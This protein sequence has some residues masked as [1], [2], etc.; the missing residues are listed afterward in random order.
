MLFKRRRWSRINKGE[1]KYKMSRQ[2]YSIIRKC[3]EF[4][5]NENV[6]SF[7]KIRELY[8]RNWLWNNKW[9]RERNNKSNAKKMNITKR[10]LWEIACRHKRRQYISS[11]IVNLCKI[12]I[13]CKMYTKIKLPLKIKPKIEW[14]VIFFQNNNKIMLENNQELNNKGSTDHINKNKC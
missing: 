4:N 9:N 6:C 3:L 5:K 1:E 11:I 8:N 2:C 12:K 13:V 7:K 14:L 10:L